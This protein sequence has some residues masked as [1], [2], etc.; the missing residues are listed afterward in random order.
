MS[1]AWAWPGTPLTPAGS[2]TVDG[3]G[4][5]IWGT[6]DAFHFVYQP[7]SGDGEIYARVASVENTD[8]WAKAGVMIRE[9]LTAGSTHAMSVVTVGNGIA[10][11]RR[12]VTDGASDHT[13]GGAY[14][15]PYWVRLVRGGDTFTGYE[16]PNGISWTV[17][18]SVTISMSND[19]YIGLAVTSHNGTELCTSG[20]DNVTVITP[21]PSPTP[22]PS[23]TPTA[24]PSPT[25]PVE[26]LLSVADS[27]VN[28]N[29]GQ[30]EL[31]DGHDHVGEEQ[32][33]GHPRYQLSLFCAVQ[34]LFHPGGGD[35]PI[36]HG[37]VV[38][39]DGTD[40]FAQL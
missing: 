1:A 9:E 29:S 10:F 35:D 2:F 24:V 15:A 17:V 26:D 36:G 22:S 6:A 27:Y 5:D 38:H 23:V 14:S 37:A 30:H 19:V 11:Q 13:A 40:G 20:I 18:G 4:A 34:C 7:L 3:D 33:R 31:R 16:S 39:A 28:Q 8:A 21:P 32:L 25:A 12:T